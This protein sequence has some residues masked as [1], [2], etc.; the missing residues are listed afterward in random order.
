MSDYF[1]IKSIRDPL[2]GFI[3]TSEIERKVIDSDAF[4]RLLN[5]KQ[6]SHEYVAYPSATHTRFE[7]SL[8]VMH[9]AGK[10]CDK[11]KLEKDYNMKELKEF[12]EITRL[13]ALLHD[14]GHGPYSHL[15]ETFLENVNGKKIS[16]EWISRLFISKDSQLQEILE[17]KAGKILQTLSGKMVN[18]WDEKRSNLANKIISG[19]L[20]VDRMDYLQRDSYHLGVTYGIF[21]L[22]RILHTI[23]YTK[24]YEEYD[25]CIQDKGKDAIEN[26]RLGRYFMHAQVYQ[27]HARLS[28]DQMFLRALDIAKEDDGL[29]VKKL[30]VDTTSFDKNDE[31]LEYY[32][33][34]N[35]ETIYNEIITR[36]PYSTSVNI[37]KDIQKR[38]LLKRAIDIIPDRDIKNNSNRRH[39][40]KMG[41]PNL[42]ELDNEIK[43]EL[44]LEY[45]QIISCLSKITSE[46]EIKA[47]TKSDRI[48]VLV[49]DVPQELDELSLINTKP[50]MKRFFV[51]TNKYKRKDVCNYVKDKFKIDNIDCKF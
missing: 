2:Y 39:V 4:R 44:E 26:Y 49:N 40:M 1:A 34:L 21:D 46:A 6:L 50:E 19:S 45:S 22:A 25:I 33:S 43:E 31:F 20:D 11:L 42:R 5:I 3:G 24:G 32:R 12:K 14:I 23:T 47:E 18:E 8:G 10:V 38:N 37:L 36:K 27:H 13:A 29:P 17:N 48:L 28:A 35:D 51:F 30:V 41:Y 15:F 9:L 16:H 7:H